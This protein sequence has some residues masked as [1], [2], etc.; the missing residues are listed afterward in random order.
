MTNDDPNLGNP[1][2]SLPGAP[3][4]TGDGDDP[5]ADFFVS[6][7]ER[8]LILATDL[9]SHEERVGQ[10]RELM[11]FW[12][13]NEEYA[14][15]IEEVREII[16][17]PHITSLPRVDGSVLG[18]ISLRG[19]IVPVMDL[20]RVLHLPSKESGR[21]TRILVLKSGGEPVG[22]L[23]DRVTSVVR[24]EEGTIEATPATMQ[25]HVS[26]MIEGVGRL[27]DRLVIILD[28]AAIFRIL[29]RAA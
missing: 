7:Q 20:R 16:K 6:A 17:V 19:T 18:I 13:A 14:L 5:F 8:E 23:V 9:V 12:V 24:F 4:G 25:H 28:A 27:D 1:P 26:E 22:L 21:H 15:P 29:E 3:A 2:E 11:A 10:A